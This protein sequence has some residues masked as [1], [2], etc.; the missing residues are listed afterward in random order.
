MLMKDHVIRTDIT[1]ILWVAILNFH[2]NNN[3]KEKIKRIFKSFIVEILNF[4]SSWKPAAYNNTEIPEEKLRAFTSRIETTIYE[5]AFTFFRPQER[6]SL[7]EGI[8]SFKG[9]PLDNIHFLM[10]RIDP[11]H[12]FRD[13]KYVGR[14][15][16]GA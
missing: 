2:A 10:L 13:D 14:T 9:I 7:N 1:Q 8:L 5:K 4:E 16:Q 12:S 3:E 6:E 15:E 11:S